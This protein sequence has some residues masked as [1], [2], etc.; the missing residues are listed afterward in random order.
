M[1]GKGGFLRVS[2]LLTHD[3]LIWLAVS[4]LRC[5]E[6]QSAESMDHCIQNSKAV[7]C[8]NSEED[9]CAK[10]TSELVMGD[11]KLMVYRK[12]CR[13]AATCAKDKDFFMQECGDDDTCEN[14]CCENNL[15]NAASFSTISVSIMF[16]SVFTAIC[17][18]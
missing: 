17:F 14:L 3:L 5:F 10:F 7:T 12:G 8:T 9:R 2:Q 13:V 16:A 6:C 15:C 4:N 1:E 18:I 11:K